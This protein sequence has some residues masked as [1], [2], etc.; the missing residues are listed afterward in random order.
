MTT[1]SEKERSAHPLASETSKETASSNADEG[2]PV[3]MLPWLQTMPLPSATAK[4]G[5]PPNTM[6]ETTSVEIHESRNVAIEAENEDEV[7]PGLDL[8][9]RQKFFEINEGSSEDAHLP[10]AAQLS[11][12]PALQGVLDETA[13][14]DKQAATIDQI[15]SALKTSNSPII[16]GSS[17]FP[18]TSQSARIEYFATVVPQT[19]WQFDATSPQIV[20]S[21]AKLAEIAAP[22][23]SVGGR[24]FGSRS[25]LTTA[26]LS[27][28][29][30]YIW[31]SDW[32]PLPTV[33]SYILTR[34]PSAIST[35]E[36]KSTRDVEPESSSKREKTPERIAS[37][38][39][40]PSVEVEP[41]ATIEPSAAVL[42][43]IDERAPADKPKALVANSGQFPGALEDR[44]QAARQVEGAGKDIPA[45]REAVATVQPSA[46][47]LFRKSSRYLDPQ[48]V[49]M[50]IAR[51]QQLM[52]T[53][54]VSAARGMFLRAAESEDPDAALALGT[55]YD[56]DVLLRLGV[57]G[58]ASDLEKAGAWYAKAES[59]GSVEARRRLE[60][61]KR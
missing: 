13:E 48:E 54:D 29:S 19:E 49:K 43:I 39:S 6:A 9:P 44:E 61:L 16:E 18:G 58:I 4:I 31:F 27:V 52:A 33:S 3:A 22:K 21:S 35:P 24:R 38:Q 51:G 11:L 20:Q 10:R 8:R 2:T 15:A 26:I 40:V 7:R 25:I 32:H 46:P 60:V 56:P 59:W 30:L 50:L 5:I 57:I 14:I 1:P 45:G 17:P 36:R 23:P 37:Q 28:A 55:A 41:A 12:I 34:L 53:G 42:S 47:P